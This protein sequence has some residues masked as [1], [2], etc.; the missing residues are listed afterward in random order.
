MSNELNEKYCCK[1]C[2][3]IL[4]R[5]ELKKCQIYSIGNCT[6]ETI[7]IREENIDTITRYFLKN[8]MWIYKC[9]CNRAYLVK[10]GEITIAERNVR[11]IINDLD[12]IKNLIIIYNKDYTMEWYPIRK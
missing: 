8:Q 11:D 9:L 4:Q 12:E 1:K 2:S 6:F 3:R 10:N 7:I 5:L